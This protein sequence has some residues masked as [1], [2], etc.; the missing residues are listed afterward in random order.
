MQRVKV[1][2]G[3]I[4]PG[5]LRVLA[6]L[7]RNCTP[8]FPI[9]L[10]TRQD[11]ELHGVLPAQ[12]P[13]IHRAL[14]EVGLTTVGACGDTL[15]NLTAC[16]GSGVCPG[17]INVDEVADALRAAAESRPFIRDMPR[18]FKI[19]VSGCQRACARPWIND[20]GLV[21]RPSGTFRAV[22]AG[23]LGARPGAGIELYEHLTPA[24][25]VP[26]TVAALRLFNAEGDRERRTK[27]RL[28]HVRKRIGNRAFA[29]RLD[30]L[31]EQAK[32]ERGWPTPVAPDVADNGVAET[33]LHLPLG[34]VTADQADDLA[35]DIERLDATARIGLAH[36]LRLYARGELALSDRLLGTA[37]APSI[38]AC[39]GSTW[40][41]RGLADSRGAARRIAAA[42]PAGCK[43]DLC[44]NGCPNN[45]GHA[46]VADIGF[47][48]RRRRIGGESVECFQLLAGGDKGAG[49]RLAEELHA[50][51]P[52]DRAADAAAWLA[53][54][55][56]SER[57]GDEPFAD[58][59]RRRR[60]ELTAGIER[61]LRS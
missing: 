39:P 2:G 49:P 8:A 38:V 31:F 41:N 9:H 19:S 30:R 56:R 35:D 51:V 27:A 3:R 32:A 43:L 57:A 24:E 44:L 42:L 25:L 52:A 23:S 54:T 12:I 58:F 18:K 15:R 46:P 40:C 6:G 16:P 45:C 55:A 1:H 26:L 11:V 13:R 7:V 60:D 47:V 29:E 61:L 21:A 20:L 10:T 5:Q 48:G 33:Q 4:T 53:R 37:A 50:A 59:V 34:D 17:T 14:A 36:E 28:R 22:L